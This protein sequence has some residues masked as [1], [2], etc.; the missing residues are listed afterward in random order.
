MTERREIFRQQSLEK[1]QSPD[2]LDSLVRIVK[3]QAWLVVAAVG[4]GMLGLLVWGIF[5]EVTA[6]ARGAAILVKPKKVVA[7][8]SPVA[9]QVHEVL[10]TVD[11]RVAAGQ[12]L[13][14]LELPALEKELQQQRQLLDLVRAHHADLR[15]MEERLAQRE[16][17]FIAE[18]RAR[19][20]Q[21]IEFV[22]RAAHSY[23]EKTAEYLDHQQG[24]IDRAIDLS[25]RLGE[26]L[27]EW[28]DG[29]ENLRA[30]GD[31]SVNEL[32]EP[33]SR[34]F[35][36]QLRHAELGLRGVELG[37]RRNRM[38]EYFDERM[39]LI[40]DL[41]LRLNRLAVL[42][43]TVERRLVEL[44]LRHRREVAEIE[45]R[46]AQIETQ[47]D[48]EAI[49]T[50]KYAGRILEVTATE[51]QRVDLA[52]AL[53]KLEIDD[54][55]A[56]LKAIAYFH[57][58]DGKKIRAG[59]TIRVSPTTVQRERFGGIEGEVETIFE[60]PVTTEA[61]AHEIGDREI[62]SSLLGGESRIQVVAR[63]AE[64]DTFTRYRWTSGDG[65][66]DIVITA[67]TTADVRVTL[68]K[69]AP[70]TLVMP[71]LESLLGGE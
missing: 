41:R 20:E 48:A 59:D 15:A 35:D 8:Q 49:V 61:A 65:P 11:E 34:L 6:T 62:A 3:P 12:V 52:Q 1:L 56:E 7:F 29:L 40:E 14:R 68:E 54:P 10:V 47:L 50:S 33:Q 22:E 27:G 13:A 53:G 37:V 43:M 26:A 31:V 64:A 39:D 5:G 16:T 36:S 46:I 67:G 60:F 18:Q 24:N 21:R 4:I 17:Q 38:E 69:R 25:A 70:I 45:Q 42:E 66:N 9:G 2:R 58:K 19:I 30:S 55:Q 71:F 51:G 63:L 57:I 28:Y 23:R 44:D 32:I